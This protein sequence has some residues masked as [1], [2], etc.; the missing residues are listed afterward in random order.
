MNYFFALNDF[1]RLLSLI[2]IFRIILIIYVIVILNK[3]D[4]KQI[5]N[6]FYKKKS[7]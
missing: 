5:N 6:E 4:F 3:F 7:R 2:I 1:Y